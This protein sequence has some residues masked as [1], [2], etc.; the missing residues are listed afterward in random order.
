MTQDDFSAIAKVF[1]ATKPNLHSIKEREL[2]DLM[3]IHFVNKMKSIHPK[4]DY[5]KFANE[6]FD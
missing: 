5:I 6:C 1:Q 3:L 4:I 2:W